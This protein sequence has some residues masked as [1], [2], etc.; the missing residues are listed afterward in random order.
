MRFVTVLGRRDSSVHHQGH[1]VHVHVRVVGVAIRVLVIQE[2]D[3]D[4]LAC[5]LGQIEGQLS[6]GA[7]VGGLLEELLNH[8]PAPVDDV[9]LL[10][11]ISVGVIA[12]WPVVETQRLAGGRAGNGYHLVGDEISLLAEAQTDLQRIPPTMGPGGRAH[13]GVLSRV[14]PTV[15]R[16]KATILDQIGGGRR[17]GGCGY[18]RVSRCGCRRPAGAELD[19]KYGVQFDAVGRYSSLTVQEVEES[20]AGDGHGYIG[21]LEAARGGVLGIEFGASMLDAGQ[22]SAGGSDAGRGGDLG[23]HGVA[24]SVAEDQVVVGVGLQLVFGQ[25]GMQLE[26]GGLGRLDTVVVRQGGRCRQRGQR[27]DRGLCRRLQID[28]ASIGVGASLYRPAFHPAG[29]VERLLICCCVA[30][31]LELWLLG[32]NKCSG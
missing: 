2:L 15:A 25:R 3:A 26:D 19:V 12:G 13:R 31:A 17:P 8:L 18:R 23:D 7:V 5:I 30:I 20:D 27:C 9:C 21:S 24:G 10:P 28:Q 1:I 14:G 6:P 16:L 32:T 4:R 11:G 22:Q 29:S